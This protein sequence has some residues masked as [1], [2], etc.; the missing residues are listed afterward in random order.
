MKITEFLTRYYDKNAKRQFISDL[1]HDIQLLRKTPCRTNGGW[2]FH[3][4]FE[5]WDKT[6]KAM[7]WWKF[8]LA[9]KPDE[10]KVL[11]CE[12]FHAGTGKITKYCCNEPK[13][14]FIL[15]PYKKAREHWR[16]TGLFVDWVEDSSFNLPEFREFLKREVL[17]EAQN[18]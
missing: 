7:E 1:C 2:Y 18:D 12:L 6:D 16:K 11:K 15:A 9:L 13:P 17:K 3:K 14:K 5:I 10:I 4:E 8:E